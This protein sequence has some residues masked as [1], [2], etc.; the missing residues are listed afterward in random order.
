MTQ[1]RVVLWTTG[2]EN[3]TIQAL[4]ESEWI[5]QGCV[6]FVV[7]RHSPAGAVVEGSHDCIWGNGSPREGV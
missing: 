1:R 5:C 7:G 4:G 6:N 3:D 2:C